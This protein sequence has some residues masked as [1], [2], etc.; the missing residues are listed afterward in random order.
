MDMKIFTL[1]ASTFCLAVSDSEGPITADFFLNSTFSDP[2]FLKTAS[3]RKIHIGVSV[4]IIQNNNDK[5]KTDFSP[6]FQ[7]DVR[8]L[9]QSV[10]ALSTGAALHWIVLTDT[11]SVVAANRLFRNIFTEHLTRN[12]LLTYLGK[13]KVRRH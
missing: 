5:N 6:G 4:R 10:L 13:G 2:R 1:L 3:P 12:I 8:T 9:V 11:N 7:R